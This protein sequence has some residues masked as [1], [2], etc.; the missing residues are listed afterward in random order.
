MDK[1]KKVK[2]YIKFK[3][4]STWFPLRQASEI[5]FNDDVYTYETKYGR[6]KLLTP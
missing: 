6:R 5:F 1:S 3:D 2:E 4:G